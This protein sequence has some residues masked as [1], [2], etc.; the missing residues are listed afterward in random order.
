MTKLIGLCL[1]L[2]IVTPHAGAQIRPSDRS[3]WLA[4]IATVGGATL[5]D[6]T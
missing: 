1:T 6:L 5:V 3:F 4:A 2:S